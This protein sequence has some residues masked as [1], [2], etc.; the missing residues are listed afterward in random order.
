MVNVGVDQWQFGVV[1]AEAAELAELT[2]PPLKL[3]Q[4]VKWL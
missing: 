4:S 1:S 2:L 3:R